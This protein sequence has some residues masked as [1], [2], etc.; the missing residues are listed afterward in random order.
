MSYKNTIVMDYDWWKKAKD[1][2]V[3][4]WFYFIIVHCLFFSP[5]KVMC[6]LFQDISGCV[7]FRK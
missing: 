6:F 1:V 7:K 2:S 3:E 4:F 5:N